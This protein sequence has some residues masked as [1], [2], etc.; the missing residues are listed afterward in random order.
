MTAIVLRKTFGG[1]LVPVDEDGIEVVRG[2]PRDAEVMV[3][4]RRSRNIKF[5]RKLFAMLD[6]V[7]HNQ[8]HYKSTADLLDVCKLRIGHVR[9]IQTAQ[10]EVRIPASISF[11]AMDNDSFNAFYKRATV[12][13][14]TE[15][16]PGLSEE[17][18]ARQV[19]ER[20]L[21]FAD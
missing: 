20:L 12:W 21:G 5:H 2:L 6:V 4:I 16:I 7:R 10:G 13:C 18:L 11:A 8:D 3:D 17:A 1:Y 15:V 14:C 19:D 9:V